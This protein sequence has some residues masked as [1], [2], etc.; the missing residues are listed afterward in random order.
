MKNT[1]FLILLL[2]LNFL[3]L[4]A[5]EPSLG[6]KEMSFAP[7]AS[8]F[9]AEAKGSSILLS[10]RDARNLENPRYHIY[11]SEEPINRVSFEKTVPLIT[12]SSGKEQYIYEPEDGKER[13]FLILAEEKG[14]LFDVFIPY[15][16]MTM[17]PTAA[18]LHVVEEEK[19]S[20]ISG[21]KVF[22]D[23]QNMTISG[24]SS[25]PERQVILFRSTE[26]MK[27][28]ADLAKAA[29]VCTLTGNNLY[30]KDQIVPGIPFY[31]ALVDRDLFDSGSDAILYE[32]SVSLE[33]VLIELN[34]WNPQKAHVFQFSTRHIPLPVLNITR[35]IEKG[36]ALPG[37]VLPESPVELSSETALKLAELKF[38]KSLHSV[39]WM[40][41]EILP[42]D[43]GE[44]INPAI[45]GIPLLL[46]NQ[47]WESVIK[48]TDREL[49]DPC[50]KE[51]EARLH[52][53]RA[54]ARY[55]KGDLEYAF[56]DFLSSRELYYSESDV[57]IYNIFKLKEKETRRER[58]AF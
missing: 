7:F 21:L 5:E 15:R 23:L 35:D 58:V 8:R 11:Y 28:R 39:M 34:E 14:Q 42:A 50:E 45:Q 51:T 1:K 30:W 17:S 54:Q 22:P 52:Y 10:W 9:K 12:L 40:E 46:E 29:R 2:I 33:S 43:K 16:N 13:Y 4:N 57:W 31:Y 19:A 24:K 36:K 49:L 20:L 6:E 48:R 18:I 41:A 25:R 47:D 3:Q 38:G 32:G 44:T 53:Y 37:P 26:K 55:F 27:V 56:M